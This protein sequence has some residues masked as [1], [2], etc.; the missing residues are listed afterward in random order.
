[1]NPASG[2]AGVGILNNPLSLKSNTD[3]PPVINKALCKRKT[4]PYIRE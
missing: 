3:L 4:N 1:M 2:A